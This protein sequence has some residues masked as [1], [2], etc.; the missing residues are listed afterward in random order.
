[1]RHSF[2]LFLISL[3]AVGQSRITKG[4]VFDYFTK[5][6]IPYVNL[7]ILESQVGTSTDE[8]GSYV[9]EIQEKNLNKYIHLSSLGY[10]DS[11]ISVVEFIKE[12]K[13][14][15]KVKTEMLEEVLI[16]K[17]IEQQFLEVNPIKKKDI[18]SGLPGFEH[19]II[20]ALFFPYEDIYQSTENLNS[21]K[22]YIR[23][24]WYYK[25]RP[26]KFRLR[27]FSIDNN[28]FPGKDLVSESII[29]ETDEK[30][31]E[32]EIDVS[33]YNLMFPKD[34]FYVGLE[35]LYIAFNEYDDYYITEGTKEKKFVKKYAPVFSCSIEKIGIYKLA[36]FYAGSWHKTPLY[37]PNKDEESVPAISLTLSN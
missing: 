5:Q 19:P 28:G 10:Q 34:G 21:I 20:A 1:M 23:H 3:T 9:L 18:K 27:L 24:T 36:L 25:N 14:Y 30:Q 6:P 17:K 7:S 8:D 32:I 15:L 31:K 22:L 13:I 33:K 35:W 12:E 16:S 4:F 37:G 26:S 29:I 2:L 11:I